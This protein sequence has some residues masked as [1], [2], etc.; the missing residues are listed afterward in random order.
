MAFSKETLQ[1]LIGLQEKDAALDKV[2]LELERIPK[3]ID[4]LKSTLAREQ[5]GAAAAKAAVQNCEKK[6][7]EKE[8]ELASKE[9]AARKHS[10]ELNSVKTNDAFKALQKEIDA[11]KKQGSD[12]ETDILVLMDEIE[13]AKKAEKAAQAVLKSAEDKVKAES[14][15]LEKQLAEVKAK[16][17]AEKAARDAS[18]EPVPNDVKK[19]YEHIRTRG[20]KDAIVPIIQDEGRKMAVS[21]KKDGE[22]AEPQQSVCSAC[23]VALAPQVVVEATKTKALVTCESCQRILYRPEVLAAAATKAS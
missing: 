13:A 8:L 17:E 2:R 3:E 12:I 23:R 11:A 10:A 1:L 14:G 20:K 7:K 5:A 16:F 4:A 21:H 22:A 9:E 19:V 18:A 6:K 15:V